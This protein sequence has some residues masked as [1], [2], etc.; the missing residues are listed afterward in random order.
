MKI[1]V[2]CLIVIIL[3]FST[4]ASS[5]S[6]SNKKV[7]SQYKCEGKALCIIGKVSRIVDGDTIYLKDYKIRLSLTSTPEKYEKGFRDAASF[8]RKLCPVGSTI[9]I[10]QDDRQPYDGYKRV[11]GKVI[12]SDKILNA[13]LL[14]NGHAT[15]RKQ[16]CLKSEFSE[17]PWAKKYGCE[18]KT[19]DIPTPTPSPTPSNEK[20]CDPSYPDFCIPPYPPDLDCGDIIYRNFR[21]LSPDPHRFD[22]DKDGIG[23]EK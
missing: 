20:R 22:V 16:Y 11:L 3:V 5:E 14:Y 17:E 19:Q 12:C 23:C 9:I 4:F 2:F 6:A 8:T 18:I 7:V 13:E 15:I 10:D 21:V 1:I